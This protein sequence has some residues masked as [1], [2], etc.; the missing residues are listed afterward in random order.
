MGEKNLKGLGR[1]SIWFAG[2]LLILLCWSAAVYAETAGTLKISLN[3]KETT[4]RITWSGYLMPADGEALTVAVWS[5]ENGQDDL[6]WRTL[7]ASSGNYTCSF[8][9]SSHAS[10]GNY[11]VHLYLR[12]KT[13]K[14][15]FLKRGVFTVSAPSCSSVKVKNLNQDTGSCQVVVS[16]LVSP[17]GI[18]KVEIPVWC[19]SNQSD[20]VWYQASLQT[21]GSWVADINFAKHSGYKGTYQIHAYATGTNKVSALVG[22]TTAAYNGNAGS[23]P[24]KVTATLKGGICTVKATGLSAPDGIRSVTV[25][26]WSETDGQDD[27]RW[28]TASYNSITATATV[29]IDTQKYCDFGPYNVHVYAVSKNGRMVFQDNTVFTLPYP[30]AGKISSTVEE[31]SFRITISDISCTAGIDRIMVPTWSAADQSDIVW[32]SAEKQSDGTYTVNSDYTKHKKHAGTYVSHVYIYDDRDSYGHFVGSTS[33]KIVDSSQPALVPKVTAMLSGTE[34]TVNAT[35]LSAPDGIKKISIAV[36]SDANGQDDLR[37]TETAISSSGSSA[38]A[39]IDLQDYRDFGSYTIH[40]Y[41]VS[42]TDKMVFQEKTTVNLPAPKAGRISTDVQKGAFTITVSDISC[43]TGI[44]KVVIPLWSAEDQSDLVWYTAQK[45]SD[46]SYTVTSDISRHKDHTGTYS[47]HVYVHDSRGSDGIN[48]GRTTFAVE[49]SAGELKVTPDQNYAVYTA[50]IADVSVP[51]A[52]ASLGMEVWTE[53]NGKDDLKWYTAEEKGSTGKAEILL[54]NH[55]NEDGIY[56][57]DFYAKQ[58]DGS[59]LLIRTYTFEVKRTNVLLIEKKGED[60]AEV[61]IRLEAA[62]EAKAASVEFPTWCASDQSDL[63]WYQ[64]VKQSDGSYMATIDTAKH[65]DHSGTYKVHCYY[66]EA[67][68]TKHLLGTSTVELAGTA[69]EL[70]GTAVI[71]SCRITGSNTVTV[72][73]SVTGSG[74]FG[75]FAL[76]AGTTELASGATP[77]ATT[78]GSGT[79]TLTAPLNANTSASLINEKLVIG[80][81]QN[82]AYKRISSGAYITNPEAAAP[83]TRAFPVAATKKGLQVNTSMPE[84]AA[85]L[86][87]KHSV[88][89][90]VLNNIPCTSGGISYKYNGKTYHMDMGY[91][92]ALDEIFAEQAANGSIVSAVLLM[93]WDSEWAD[94]IIPSG[95]TAGYAFYGLNAEEQQAREQLAA[96]FSFLAERYSDS[97]HNVVNWILGN[98]VDDYTHYNWCG[99][100]GLQEYASYYAHAYRLLYNSV[101]SRYSNARVY[102]SLD[103][104][105]NYPRS[106][107]FKGKELF[108][109]FVAALQAE[110]EINWNIAFHP[111][112]NPITSPNFW[113]NRTGVT[114]SS[115]SNIFTMYNLRY[116]TDYIRDTYGAQHR[117]ILSEA[118]FTSYS[119]GSHDE[120]LQAAAIAYA[121]YLAEFNDMVDSFVV[122]RHVDNRNEMSSGL[123]LGL[124]YTKDGY[125][126]SPS[127][128]KISWDVFKYMDTNQGAAY[129]NFALSIIGADSWNSIVPGYSAARF[130]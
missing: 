88:I 76:K 26:V 97:G 20:I 59:R 14:M 81:M 107:G 34:C 121:Y 126:E 111:Y 116:L 9:V 77:L 130:N 6:K 52:Y 79:I 103:H 44:A 22:H 27:L 106:Y 112:P 118:G 23:E 50:E 41:A 67:N 73:A 5:E 47:A 30:S 31:T 105:W 3:T 55:N 68:G 37:W 123:Y 49:R 113:K 74:T 1:V 80:Q 24:P 33:F 96:I 46:G 45:K 38:T 129:T 102:I 82:G 122:N 21:D 39:K 57:L 83:N 92:Y 128:K 60:K 10:A 16:G 32:Y 13:G 100:I 58:S 53:K 110:G 43:V 104:V 94:L 17:S 25:A 64:A 78:T 42:K 54:K 84:D 61:R 117:F 120:S 66:N 63:V 108:E 11:N 2:L 85:E 119:G 12:T 15:V 56:H 87:V 99:N 93:Q 65:K 72:T 62:D 7:G 36:W 127:S 51:E 8:S 35:G 124:W 4:C 98:E 71:T 75:L 101:K 18:A 70:A 28:T 69:A 91:I 48:S 125:T 109:A 89:N 86:G 90:V 29:K 95:R 19:K 40:V 114:N 115:S